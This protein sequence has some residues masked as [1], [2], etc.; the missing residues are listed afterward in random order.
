[1]NLSIFG[2]RLKEYMFYAGLNSVS[3]SK[4]IG[5]SR[6]TVSELARGE[7]S[8]S[9]NTFI[10]L[11]E[12]FNCSADY[13]LGLSNDSKENIQFK[14]VEPF[15]ERL[16]NLIENEHKSQYGLEKQQKIS[17]SIVYDWLS[18]KYLPSIENLAKVAKYFDRSI[19]YI[20]G[21]EK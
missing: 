17:G 3:L 11:I 19:D 20:L 10:K 21:R 7:F 12:Y 18:G 15:G 14:P 16:R 1:M 6:T 4:E 5:V 2:E 13:L 9:F 8:P